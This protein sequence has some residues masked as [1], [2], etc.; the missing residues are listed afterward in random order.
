M[1]AIHGFARE[2]DM[3]NLLK[4]IESGVSV[5]L[6][7]ELFRYLLFQ[8]YTLFFSVLQVVSYLF[9]LKSFGFQIDK[10]PH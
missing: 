10:V 6:K 9:Y 7:G 3:T 2:G 5:N 1:D 4:C 8:V